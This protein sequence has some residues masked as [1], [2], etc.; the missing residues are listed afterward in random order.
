MIGVV[1][2][3]HEDGLQESAPT[4]AYYPLLMSDFENHAV[5]ERR[6]V[7][8]VVRS[9]RAGSPALL[10]DVQSAIRSLNPNLPLARIRT[11][12]EIYDRSLARTSFVLVM[13]A[14]AGAMALFIGLVGIY[15]VISYAV[16]QRTREIGV[17]MALGAQPQRILA[18]ILGQGAAMVISGVVI[19]TACALLLTRFLSSMLFGVRPQDPLTY[20]IVVLMLGAIALLACYLP[21]RRATRVEP[22]VALRH[23]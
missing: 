15:G 13:L 17:R 10:A 4:T 1:N 6:T 7:Y 2:D 18:W 14:I 20:T 11:L 8:Y 23:E 9:K 12:Q 5:A 21:A 22:M 19:G 3:V 16:S